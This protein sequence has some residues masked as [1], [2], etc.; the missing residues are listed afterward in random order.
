MRVPALKRIEEIGDSKVW[1]GP[2]SEVAA[3]PRRSGR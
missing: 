1:A 3:A 2:S